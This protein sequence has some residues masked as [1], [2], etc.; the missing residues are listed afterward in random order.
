MSSDQRGQAMRQPRDDQG[1][2]CQAADPT[3][4]AT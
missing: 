4:A 3:V 2:L 1:G